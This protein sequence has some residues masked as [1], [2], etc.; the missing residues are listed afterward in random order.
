LVSR[1][2]VALVAAGLALACT[3]PA[4]AQEKTF[5]ERAKEYWEKVLTALESGAKSAGDEYHKLKAEAATASGPA[6]EK[7]AKE[8]EVAREKW[9][10]AREKLTAS[11]EHHAHAAN[12]ELKA[13]EA[14]AST[15]SGSA[16]EKWDAEA[17]VLRKHWEKAREKVS[18]AFSS[19]M[20]AAGD[21]YAHLR[22]EAT[23]ATEDAKTKLRPQ[24][25]KLKAEW[26]TNRDKLIAFL[27]EDLRRTE[28]DLHKIGESTSEAAKALKEKLT[29][30]LHELREK[31]D[32]LTNEKLAD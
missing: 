14:K 17:E 32:S 24:M 9:A 1:S 27:K 28:E 8:M 10:A 7:L 29:R 2:L 21:E 5:T 19:N 31:Y 18:T 15:A 25:E 22:D 23:K 3:T 12:E 13:L 11:L 16:R 30:K 26:A 6:R 4:A 20:K